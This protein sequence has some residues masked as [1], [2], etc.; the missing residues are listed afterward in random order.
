MFPF[1]S[2]I[3]PLCSIFAAV[4]TSY[5][6]NQAMSLRHEMAH[7]KKEDQ[8]REGSLVTKKKGGAEYRG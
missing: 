7:A 2:H 4:P 1:T 6:R 3:L 8:K 5:S